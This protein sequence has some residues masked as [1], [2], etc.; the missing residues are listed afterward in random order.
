MRTSVP[1]VLNFHPLPSGAY[2]VSRSTP[3]GWERGGGRRVFTHCLIVPPDVMGRFANNPFALAE[4]MS[5]KR[6]LARSGVAVSAA[7]AVSRRRRALRRSTSRSCAGWAIEPGP[8]SVAR[9][10]QQV[11]GAVCLAIAGSTQPV[12][13]MAGLFSCL[14]PE[15][16]LEFFVFDGPEVLAVAT[17]PHCHA[18]GTIR[19]ERL[20]VASY[21]NVTVLEVGLDAEA[22]SGPL[23]GWARLVETGFGH[24][25]RALFRLA[26]FQTS[27][28]FDAGRPAGPL[29][30]NCWK[31]L[32]CSNFHAEADEPISEPRPS[33]GPVA[34]TARPNAGPS[35]GFRKPPRPPRP[36]CRSSGRPSNSACTR[37]KSSKKLE[38][39]D[40]LVYEAISG[41][42]QFIGTTPHRVAGDSR[43]VGRRD[44]GPNRGSSICG[45]PYRSGRSAPTAKASEIRS[46]PF[47]PSR[48]SACS[49]RRRDMKAQL[50][51]P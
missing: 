10:V 26:G 42:D 9:L 34:R 18:F 3:A 24:R 29:G 38:Y 22:V 11:R 39:L 40:D 50:V 31:A 48:C 32:D 47:T 41:Q 23:D 30:C 49:L 8:Q 20:W 45:T 25:P 37:R 35:T 28:R 14:P 19:P 12:S 33:A 46:R 36:H 21:P 1:R 15:C 44:V 7:E 43:R 16:R 27:V 5:E 13:L 6:S 17:V 51:M 2:C 4:V